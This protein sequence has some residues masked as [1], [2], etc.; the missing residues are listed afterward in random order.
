MKPWLASTLAVIGGFLVT[1]VASIAADA[2]MYSTGV[3][4]HSPVAMSATLFGLAAAYRAM[5][6]VAGGYV[7]ARFAPNRPMRHAWIL[8]GIGQAAGI[9][10]VVAWYVIGG[11]E[12]GPAWYAILI[13]AEAVPCVLL[14]AWLATSRRHRLA[15]SAAAKQPA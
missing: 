4:P 6:T 10:G 8:A 1:A 7:T 12:L 3:F 13:A 15:G 11:A 9:A 14:G 2:L 5:F